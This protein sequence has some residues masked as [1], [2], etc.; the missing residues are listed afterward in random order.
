MSTPPPRS[1]SVAAALGVVSSSITTSLLEVRARIR[2]VR[3][4]S[5]RNARHEA[6]HA[7]VAWACG[8]EVHEVSTVVVGPAEGRTIWGKPYVFSVENAAVLT[9]GNLAERRRDPDAARERWKLSHDLLSLEEELSEVVPLTG[10]TRQAVLEEAI[11]IAHRALGEHRAAV[12]ALAARL[13]LEP[14]TMEGSEAVAIIERAL[15]RRRT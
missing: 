13:A 12:A 14:V 3:P 7:V 10:N 6:G 8:L 5:V 9:A 1:W 4:E 2:R 11:A 15:G